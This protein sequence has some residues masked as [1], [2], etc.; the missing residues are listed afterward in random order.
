MKQKLHSLLII[1]ILLVTI[2]SI[3]DHSNVINESVS[4]S[5]SLFA[6]NIFPSLFP[7][8]VLSSVL[9]AIGLP[10]FL[11][12]LFAKLMNKV[13]KVKGVASFVFFM[14]MITGFPSSAKYINDLMEKDVIDYND[15][16]K[17]L[18][19]TFFSNPLFIVNT[20]GVM[21]FNS[22]KIGYIILI[23]HIL[24][25]IFVGLIFRNFLISKQNEYLCFKSNLRA[26]HRRINNTN[27][28]KALLNGIFNAVNNLVV[29]FGIVT[30]FMI[31]IGLLFPDK[32]S[33]Y[34]V[35]LSGFLE[36][37]TGLK[38]ISIS[39]LDFYLKLCFSMFFI[40][41]G[42]FSIHTQIMNILENKKVRYLPFLLARLLHGFISVVI[43]LLI[44]YFL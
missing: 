25:N 40:S 4:L 31:I 19:F 43:L 44:F 27:V 41:F 36:M 18:L 17:I 26:F 10:E 16:S 8:F 12:N 13:F 9:V 29:I 35:I 6:N 21:F 15:A 3:F 11:G 28:F 23:S 37:T 2:I 30:T 38:Y 5:F 24:G 22:A 39:D 33:V 20:V 34:S 42:G 14:S 7:M 32:N 1:G